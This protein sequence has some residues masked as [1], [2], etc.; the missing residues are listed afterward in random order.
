MHKKERL[1][2]LRKISPILLFSVQ[3]IIRSS[4]S[5]YI[6][7]KDWEKKKKYELHKAVDGTSVVS[8]SKEIE[9][10]KQAILRAVQ[11]HINTLK[12]IKK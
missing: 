11:L 8:V 3:F 2:Y 4:R 9:T 5:S 6:T 12:S 7:C 10:V 1:T